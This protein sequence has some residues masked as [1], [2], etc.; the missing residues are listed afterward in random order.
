MPSLSYESL[1][2]SQ[3]IPLV[4][5]AKTPMGLW[6]TC[7]STRS[8]GTNRSQVSGSSARPSLQKRMAASPLATNICP[9]SSGLRPSAESLVA[10][11][12]C[13][14]MSTRM[15]RARFIPSSGGWT[16]MGGVIPSAR[17]WISVSP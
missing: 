1:T 17:T 4:T 2:L 8:S 13:A 9:V 15:Q 16:R 6:R 14:A 5:L 10:A 7:V 3:S 12:C 11:S